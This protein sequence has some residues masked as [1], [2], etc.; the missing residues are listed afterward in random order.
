MFC[1]SFL[2][3]VFNKIGVRSEFHAPLSAENSFCV[4]MNLLFPHRL[5]IWDHETLWVLTSGTINWPLLLVFLFLWLP[6][7][8]DS[9][10]AFPVH[11]DLVNSIA[12]WN[13]VALTSTRIMSL[14][15]MLWKIVFLSSGRSKNSTDAWW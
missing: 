13:W 7:S 3:L 11:F 5:A 6:I 15:C 2:L 1:F 14:S 10:N 4:W 12:H 9:K 8:V